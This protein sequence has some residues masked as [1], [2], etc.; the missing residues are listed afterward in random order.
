[1]QEKLK[2]KKNN[3]KNILYFGEI[4]DPKTKARISQIVMQ[5]QKQGIK[6]DM[7][8]YFSTIARINNLYQEV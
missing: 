1:M 7:K 8:N 6:I 3:N 5:N 2:R 4:G